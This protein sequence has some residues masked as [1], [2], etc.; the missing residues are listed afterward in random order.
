MDLA[1][2]RIIAGGRRSL[3]FPGL[4]AQLIEVG[5]VRELGMT[6]LLPEPGPAFRA[7]NED[8]LPWSGIPR[9]RR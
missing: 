5:A 2:G 6:G 9:R 1:P 8:G 7:L 4:A 3:Q